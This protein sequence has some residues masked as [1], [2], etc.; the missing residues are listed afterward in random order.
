M[1]LLTGMGLA[2]LCLLATPRSEGQDFVYERLWPAIQQPWYFVNTRGIAVDDDDQVFV[3]DSFNHRI[4]RFTTDGQLSFRFGQEGVAPGQFL[5]PIAVATAP[6]G[7][8]YVAETDTI[9][10]R[11][12]QRLDDTGRPIAEFGAFGSGP[13]RFGVGVPE[14]NGL[15]PFELEVDR[16]GNVWVGGSNRIQRFDPD[17]NFLDAI[18]AFDDAANPFTFL[19]GFD[20]APD[21]RIYALDG[22]TSEILVFSRDGQLQQRFGEFG[23][24]A[25]QIF[26]G[27]DLEIDAQGRVYIADGGNSKVIR[28]E[29]DF[30]SFIEWGEP[31]TGAGQ[32]QFVWRLD[33]DSRGQVF[34]VDTAEDDF[35]MHRVQKFTADGEFLQQWTAASSDP[36]RFIQPSGVTAAPDGRIYVAD[37]GNDR[38]QVFSRTGEFLFSFGER[39]TGEGQFQRPSQLAFAPDGKLFVVEFDGRRVQRFLADGTYDGAVSGP[40]DLPGGI[41]VDAAG[42]VYV[43]ELLQ[44]RVLKFDASLAPIRDWGGF[45]RCIEEFT[46]NPLACQDG[47]FNEPRSLTIDRSGDQELIVVG[48]YFN[49]R[50]Q[51]FDTDGNFVDQTPLEFFPTAIVADGEGG[52]YQ[53]PFSDSRSATGH[54]VARIDRQGQFVNGWGEY[55]SNPGQLNTPLGLTLTPEGDLVVSDTLNH[56]MVRFTDAANRVASKAIIVAGGGPYAGNTLWP[57]TQLN[58]NFAYRALTQQGFINDTIQYLSADRALDLDGNGLEDDVD[59]DA[60]AAELENAITE[61]AAD[62]ADVV[63]YLVDHGGSETFRLSGTELLG[64][65]ALAGWIDELQQQ[66]GGNLTVVYDACRSGSFHAALASPASDR[67]VITSADADQS[68]FF[69]DRGALSFSS[70]FWTQVFNGATVGTAFATAADITVASFPEQTPLLDAD[71][72]GAFNQDA[73]RQQV[74]ERRIGIGVADGGERPVIGS[75]SAP[76]QLAS[77]SVA[78]LVADGV[79]DA[80]GIARVWAVI[81]P[82]GGVLPRDPN[83]PVADLPARELTFQNDDRS[84]WEGSFDGFASPGIYT[85]TINAAD[86][87]GNRAIPRVTTVTVSDPKERRAIVVDSR[88]VAAGKGMSD[89]AA[90]VVQ[91]LQAQDYTSEQVTVLSGGSGAEVDALPL[92]QAL[93]DALDQAAGGTTR[94][95]LVAIG[96]RKGPGG[97]FQLADSELSGDEFDMMLDTVQLS[98]EGTLMVV[99]DGDGA[100]DFV[101]AIAPDAHQSRIVVA[102]A[103]AEQ[104]AVF[105]FGGDLSFTRAFWEQVELGAGVDDAFA[106]AEAFLLGTASPQVPVLEDNGNGIGNDGTDGLLAERY[107][108]GAGIVVAGDPPLI[109]AISDPQSLDGAPSARVVVDNVTSTGRVDR[110]LARITPPGSF[111]GALPNK[112]IYRALAP[113]GPDSF[114][115]D[116]E[117]FTTR[118]EYQVAVYAIDEESQIS[119][120]AMTRVTQRQGDLPAGFTVNSGISGAWFD[121][122]HDGEGWLIQVLD[123]TTALVYWFTYRPDGEGASGQIWIGAQVGRIEGPN[124]IVEQM[125]TTAGPS[126]GDAFD[127]GLLRLNP[128]GDVT[129]NFDDCR[130]GR[131]YYRGRDGFRQG[132]LNI[133]RITELLGN[134]C[135]TGGATGVVAKGSSGDVDAR[136]SGAWFDPTRNGEGWLLEI[137]PGDVALVV[138]FTYGE[139][140]RQRWLIGTGSVAGTTIEF[141]DMRE[142]IGAFFGPAFDPGSV[143]RAAWGTMSFTFE[144]CN[145][146]TM[147]YA[148]NDPAIGSGTLDLA[149][150]TKISGLAC[151]P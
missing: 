41:G 36:G 139:Q 26:I 23:F 14:D 12:I 55:G 34:T 61:W 120:P 63:V 65:D 73:D 133:Q 126:F 146:G 127:G 141:D 10:F 75:V 134:D 151:D 142:P 89:G 13:G 101:P 150:L 96:G 147:T 52:V 72:D 66:I 122:S 94:D 29:P 70:H 93:Q 53:L 108:I 104:E 149:A 50:L 97:G 3:V 44:N 74:A 85:V 58:A 98:L 130:R 140:G 35:G 17:G 59:G 19:S 8:I 137:L 32:F 114:A 132:T 62:A 125:I 91:A 28:F 7:T 80:D 145:V 136:M 113:I 131:M 117:A 56:R 138:W 87:F 64:A 9:D 42:S 118:G 27:N 106:R 129:F 102:S 22:G 33:F 77:T 39:G 81:R 76:S 86:N 4:H 105:E 124:I 111:N 121:P 25:G 67:V 69:V 16:D 100:A 18:P 71:G 21:G 148:A 5:F 92:Q 128:W 135:E 143:D 119:P 82:P 144:N 51:R 11:R 88:A 109:G 68:A 49:L 40:L 2:A 103:G 47:Q 57:A 45:T 115:L 79:Q 43:T 112:P 1:R 107:S 37:E 54:F 24:E 116:F 60:T 123:E 83:D 78:T 38:V 30:Q 95:L 31:G 110:A 90:I 99:Y 46:G 48:D 20:L 15:S 6:D 84:R